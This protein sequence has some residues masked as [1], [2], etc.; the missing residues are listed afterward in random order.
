MEADIILPASL[1]AYCSSVG[2]W[3]AALADCGREAKLP[4]DAAAIHVARF[5]EVVPASDKELAALPMSAHT[6][7]HTIPMHRRAWDEQFPV[8]AAFRANID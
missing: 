7:G 3:T 6:T 5:H 4:S 1:W 8:P 2:T